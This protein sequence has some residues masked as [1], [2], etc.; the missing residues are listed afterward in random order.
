VT[1]KA[2]ETWRSKRNGPAWLER[3][4]V[5]RSDVNDLDPFLANGRQEPLKTAAQAC[6]IERRQR[7]FPR[8]ANPPFLHNRS[9]FRRLEDGP[10]QLDVIVI[11]AVARRRHDAFDCPCV[12]PHSPRGGRKSNTE[13]NADYQHQ[14]QCHRQQNPPISAIFAS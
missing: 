1:E 9:R 6:G 10:Q 14:G 11:V 8:D 4:R 12:A 3:S 13:N 5:I 2:L 7:A